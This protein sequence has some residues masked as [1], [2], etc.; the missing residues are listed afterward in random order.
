MNPLEAAIAI[1]GLVDA[2][3]H[4]INTT[5]A[6]LNAFSTPIN[7]AL[8]IGSIVE[9]VKAEYKKGTSGSDFEKGEVAGHVVANIAL[10]AAPYLK[11]AQSVD[12]AEMTNTLVKAGDISEVAARS[13]DN[14]NSLRGASM[15]EVKELIPEHWDVKPLKKGGGVRYSNPEN[16]NQT[17]MIEHG[18]SKSKDLL[19]QGPY[20][21]ITKDRDVL[22]IPLEGNPTLNK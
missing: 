19:H 16:P 5:K 15:K 9:G 4:P 17:I 21:R 18:N 10:F 8:T 1:G 7:S 14:P 2:V 22:R 13:L 20:V 11:A 12:L 6:I 3:L